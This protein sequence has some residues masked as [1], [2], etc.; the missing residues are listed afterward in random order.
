MEEIRK[1]AAVLAIGHS[2]RDTFASL[3]Q[4]GV[5]LERKPFAVGVRIEHAREFIDK[6]Q[7]GRFAGEQSL[8]A[9]E[10]VLKARSGARGV[11]SF[12][13]C[14]GGEVV[15]SATEEGTVSYTHLDVYKRQGQSPAF[16]SKYA[17][18]SPQG[19]RL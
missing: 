18:K 16:A 5:V 13:M 4:R 7:Y 12:C 3:L 6:N 19:D 9:A 8:G 11:Y 1:N 14:P 17:A 15:C 2:A 10:Y